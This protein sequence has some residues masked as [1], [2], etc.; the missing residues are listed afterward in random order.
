MIWCAI[1]VCG[2]DNWG[3]DNY[4]SAISVEGEDNCGFDDGDS[5]QFQSAAMTIAVSTTILRNF[6][7]WRGQLPFRQGFDGGDDQR[8]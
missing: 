4:L 5:A 8:F 7:G 2:E 6:D 1:S 3:F